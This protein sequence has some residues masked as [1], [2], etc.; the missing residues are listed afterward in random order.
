R[1][2]PGGGA[3]PRRRRR[4]RWQAHPAPH[5]VAR[6]A[7]PGRAR[8]RRRAG[9]RGAGNQHPCAARG[10]RPRPKKVERLC[11]YITRP[12]IAGGRLEHRPDGR[13]ELTLK[14]I[15]K[16]GTRAL[17]FEPFDLL[18]RLVAA[19]PPPRFHMIRYF[20]VL[21]SRSALRSEVVPQPAEDDAAY[22]P[23]PAPGDQLE[24]V[25]THDDSDDKPA[26]RRRRAWLLRHVFAEDLESCIRCGGPM[27]W[28]EVATA[29]EDIARLLAEHGLDNI[30]PRA[31]PSRHAPAEQLALPFGG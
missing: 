30:P 31:P 27:R 7:R 17:V 25:L 18:A 21:S 12:P 3:R 23:P 29:P 5:P 22:Q 26:P 6:T 28:I 13:F 10:G 14:S 8:C 1:L 24:L 2:L 4:A 15:W 16:D 19:V 20:G 9:R 11:K